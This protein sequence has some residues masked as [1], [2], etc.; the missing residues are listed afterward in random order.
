MALHDPA[1]DRWFNGFLDR[2]LG[3]RLDPAAQETAAKP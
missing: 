1:Q 3:V 2:M